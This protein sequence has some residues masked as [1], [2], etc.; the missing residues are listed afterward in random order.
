VQ[1]DVELRSK[2]VK[3]SASLAGKKSTT[4]GAST[5][6]SV[7]RARAL[8]MSQE[9]HH[10]GSVVVKE[11]PVIKEVIKEVRVEVPKVVYVPV[12]VIKEVREA[13]GTA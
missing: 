7:S 2:G 12:E 1:Q 8:T 10:G 11:V 4:V 13:E 3:M 5:V 6:P 9:M